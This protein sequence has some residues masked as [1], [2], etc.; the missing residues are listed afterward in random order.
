MSK[1]TAPSKPA[2]AE[3]SGLSD[4]LKKARAITDGW[5]KNQKANIKSQE[6]H[7]KAQQ[8]MQEKADANR[9]SGA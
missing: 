5:A 2:E 8:E 9:D 6:R 1:D 7:D 3:S 4:L